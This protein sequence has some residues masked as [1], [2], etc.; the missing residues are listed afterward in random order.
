MTCF[1]LLM[2]TKGRQNQLVLTPIRLPPNLM[3]DFGFNIVIQV[4]WPVHV[5]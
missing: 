2:K 1:L 4:E 5:A 3:T